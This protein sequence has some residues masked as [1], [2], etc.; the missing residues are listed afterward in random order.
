MTSSIAVTQQP[1]ST[2]LQQQLVSTIKYDPNVV[3][4][5]ANHK[6]A[7]GDWEGGQFIFQSYLLEWT[8]DAR[9][10]GGGIGED[11][12]GTNATDEGNPLNTT[13]TQTSVQ[14]QEAI[15][16]LYIA[17]AQYLILAKQY[18]TAT[19][20]YEDAIHSSVL[21]TSI[22]RIYQEYARFLLEREKRKSAQD[23]FVQALVTNGGAV[24]DEQDREI[25]WNDFLEMM[26]TNNPKLTMK[27]LRQAMIERPST[28]S[29]KSISNPPL[30]RPKLDE[31][32]IYDDIVDDVARENDKSKD[33]MKTHV[34]TLESVDVEAMKLVKAW[35]A[36]L[37]SSTSQSSASGGGVGGM[38][39]DIIAAWISR[40][41]NDIPYPPEPPLF[42]PSPP[43][44]SDPVCIVPI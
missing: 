44:L 27:A 42:A 30:K 10:G 38:P 36:I 15:C 16:T 19:L 39:P 43:K 41:G 34:V 29:K 28:T 8:D 12:F 9:E 24:K 2:T 25:L 20:V 14:L 35:S 33:A 7:S 32:N 18:K 11:G 4:A 17:Y 13:N 1:N 6:F 37:L 5:E 3:I 21:H 31:D 26:Q 23:I 40:D 22:G